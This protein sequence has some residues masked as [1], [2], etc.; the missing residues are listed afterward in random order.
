M[1]IKSYH[2]WLRVYS[3][4]LC[5]KIQKDILRGVWLVNKETN[6]LL[7]SVRFRSNISFHSINIMKSLIHDSITHS[8]TSEFI[9]SLMLGQH[10]LVSDQKK[11]KKLEIKGDFLLCSVLICYNFK[12]NPNAVVMTEFGLAERHTRPSWLHTQRQGNELNSTKTYSTHQRIL[13]MIFQLSYGI[14]VTKSS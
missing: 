7:T 6:K 10:N 13:K 14:L 11:R 12:V 1:N 3:W 8:R 2:A 9:W 5:V 4:P